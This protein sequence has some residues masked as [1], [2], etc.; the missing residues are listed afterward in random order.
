[1]HFRLQDTYITD[2]LWAA[3]RLIELGRTTSPTRCVCY[4]CDLLSYSNILHVPH[5]G[6]EDHLE[7]GFLCHRPRDIVLE[8]LSCQITSLFGGEVLLFDAIRF[9]LYVVLERPLHL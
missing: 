7:P 3:R 4:A 6:I 8:P 9:I 5:S 2:I 1:M